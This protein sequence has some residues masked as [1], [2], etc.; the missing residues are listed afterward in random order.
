M[1]VAPANRPVASSL[2]L[3]HLICSSASS[4]AASAR[5]SAIASAVAY[6]PASTRV[7]ET[8]STLAAIS[9]RRATSRTLVSAT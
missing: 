1:R 2:K 9:G 3:T 4:V 8:R 7:R 6:E 5:A